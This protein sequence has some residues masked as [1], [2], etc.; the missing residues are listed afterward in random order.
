MSLDARHHYVYRLSDV[1]TGEFYVGV[2]QC[3][4]APDADTQY[5]GSGR[6]PRDAAY[7]RRPIRKEV[8]ATFET[9]ALATEAELLLID[10]IVGDLFCRNSVKTASEDVKAPF[11]TKRGYR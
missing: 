2:R 7:D 4:C 3:R 5:M 10:M 1:E 9:R 8:L 6:W 11:R